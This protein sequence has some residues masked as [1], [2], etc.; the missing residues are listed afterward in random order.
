MN[1]PWRWAGIWLTLAIN[2]VAGLAVAQEANSQTSQTEMAVEETTAPEVKASETTVIETAITETTIT[3]TINFVTYPLVASE[4]DSRQYRYLVL[5]NKLRLLLVSDPEAEKSAAA[6]DVHIGSNQNPPERPGLAHF[7]EHML[8]L[9]TAKYP[10]AG[11]FQAFISQHSGRYNA[12]T[13]AEHTNYFFDIDPD[14]LEPALDRFAQFF[15]APLMDADYVERERRAVHSEFSNGLVDDSRRSLDVYRELLNPAH[16]SAGFTVGN[17]DSLADREDF[18]IREDLWAFYRTH[19]TPELMSLVVLGRQSLDELQALVLP[20][21]AAI[22]SQEAA[23]PPSYPPLFEDDFLP[24]MVSIR[25]EKELRQL[26]FMFPIPNEDTYYPYKPFDFIAHLLA[27]EGEG[28]LFALLKELGWV[29]SLH[30]GTGLRSRHDGLF[31]INLELTEKGARAR[32]QIPIL[33][34]HMLRQ[35]EARGLREWRYL[36]LQ[37]MGEINFR[38]LQKTPPLETVRSL[39]LAMHTYSPADVLQGGFLFRAYDEKLIKEALGFLRSDRVLVSFMS[40]DVE[41]E[42]RSYYYQTP[43]AVAPW[44]LPDAEVKPAIRKRLNLPEP[45]LFI[46]SRLGVKSQPLLPTPR[47]LPENSN[48]HAPQLVVAHHRAKAWFKQDQVFEQPRAQLF[49]RLKLPQVAQ[50]V[51]GAARAHLFAALVQDQLS[52]YAYPARLAGLNYSLGANPRGL[53]I[54]ISGYSSRQG[55]LLNTIADH[56]RR[57]RFA[58]ERFEL[59]KAELVREWRNQQKDSPYRVLLP[60]IP[61]LHMDPYWSPRALG[62]A[63]EGEGFSEFQQFAAKILRDAELE[64]VFY[65]NLYQQEAIK[66]AALAEHQ[67]LGLR[68]G[69]AFPEARVFR[70]TPS[71]KPWHY[72]LSLDH[73]DQIAVLYLQALGDSPS[74]AAHMRLL[75][76]ILQPR[77]FDQLRTEKQLGYVV[78]ALPLALRQLEGIAFVVQSPTTDEA[79]LMKEIAQFMQDQQESLADKLVENRTALMRELEEPARSL[80]D[81]ASRYRDSLLTGDTQFSRRRQLAQAMSAITEESLKAYFNAVMLD[82]RRRLW[83]TSD[84]T[85]VAEQ[86]QSLD[87]PQVYR[88]R[89]IPLPYH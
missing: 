9:G 48:Q 77:F 24:A 23:L 55:L 49:L 3:E 43:Y 86:F 28:S 88:A 10:E 53:E 6:L 60:E 22:R 66:L 29:E 35:I 76:Q 37:Q 78:G 68:T 71:D 30:A 72:S 89:Q 19:Y 67:L 57:A 83:L 61:A 65:G 42:R 18:P 50:G 17:L 46:P 4:G 45:N 27:H 15:I 81:Q 58:P 47:D 74:D 79:N 41:V 36:E 69:R 16:P 54:E 63:L 12:Y 62:Q 82:E 56:V 26:S 44:A 33:V 39:A 70:M 1:K 25:P 64:A 31:Y 20:R 59:L 38:F 5:P 80:E 2:L 32:E 52:E 73:H 75:R 7:L 85:T 40:P 84:K 14:Q 87:D 8:F 51:E 34:F 11:E 21:F 13:A